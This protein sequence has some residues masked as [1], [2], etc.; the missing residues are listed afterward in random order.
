MSAVAMSRN[1]EHDMKGPGNKAIAILVLVGQAARG[2]IMRGEIGIGIHSG[3]PFIDDHATI[4]ELAVD[5]ELRSMRHVMIMN[6]RT[7]IAWFIGSRGSIGLEE[8]PKLH[9]GG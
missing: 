7:N 4:P 1:L 5:E 2:D 6:R 3:R 8:T 9:E